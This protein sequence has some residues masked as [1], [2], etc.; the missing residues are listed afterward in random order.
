MLRTLHIVVKVVKLPYRLLTDA[1]STASVF[2]TVGGTSGADAPARNDGDTYLALG[3]TKLTLPTRR[4]RR[5]GSDLSEL[6]FGGSAIGELWSSIPEGQAAE[7]IVR[8]LDAGI[9]YFDT[10]PWYGRGLSELRLGAVL[11]GRERDDFVLSSKVGRVL[12]APLP[13]R[14]VDRRPWAGGLPFEHRHDYSYDGIMRSFDDSLQRLGLNRIDLLLIHDLDHWHHDTD[15]RVNAYMAQLY[16][17]GWRALEEL[18]ASGAVSGIG[19]GINQPGTMRQ[20]LEMVD[21]DFFLVALC[22]TLLDQTIL[23]TEMAQAEA[24][25]AGFIIGGVFNSGILATGAREGARY[26]YAPATADALQ[27]VA[28]IESVCRDN[29]VSL[30]SAALQFPL[31]HPAVASVIPGAL[32]AAEVDANVAAWKAPIPPGFWSDLRGAGVLGAAV[33]T[34]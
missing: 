13:G 15:A 25:G 5:T 31:G 22:Y 4:L 18:R 33:P 6:G 28:A 16:T 34:P 24:R 11:R 30:V 32:S 7:A 8:A 2:V 21:L 26:N 14:Q 3:T 1:N 20:F 10:S 9:S 19:A 17:S 27:R 29:K 12:R 23:E